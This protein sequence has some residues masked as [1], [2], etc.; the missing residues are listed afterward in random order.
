MKIRPREMCI[1]VYVA[2]TIGLVLPVGLEMSLNW[3]DVE[4]LTALN[5]FMNR[6][7]SLYMGMS[8]GLFAFLFLY[9]FWNRPVVKLSQRPIMLAIVSVLMTTSFL[10]VIP[11]EEALVACYIYG[12]F[13]YGCQVCLFALF[14][15]KEYRIY[16][17]YQI[18]KYGKRKK[19]SRIKPYL[20]VV[21]ATGLAIMVN[22][23]ARLY[24]YSSKDFNPCNMDG[25]DRTFA[26]G[27]YI[28]EAYFCIIIFIAFLTAVYCFKFPSICG[29][30]KSLFMLSLLGVLAIILNFIR[31]SIEH[32]ED[33]DVKVARLRLTKLSLTLL[34]TVLTYFS[35]IF[36]RVFYLASTKSQVVSMFLKMD[37]VNYQNMMSSQEEIQPNTSWFEQETTKVLEEN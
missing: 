23:M 36:E 2:V 14:A 18:V 26:F 19:L 29:D 32:N 34:I 9:V 30:S 21:V 28:R 4:G 25:T 33:M 15:A 3:N 20:Y 22:S 10:P 6:S 7:L 13:T 27:K 37:L 31:A 8:L 1:A 12:N 35:V 17:I 16:E 24:P 5:D 11:H